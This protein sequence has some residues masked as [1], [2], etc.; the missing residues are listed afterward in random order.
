MVVTTDIKSSYAQDK[1]KL[2]YPRDDKSLKMTVGPENHALSVYVE[3]AVMTL[4]AKLL[5]QL[6]RDG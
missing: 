2:C 4:K 5:P 3:A 6:I 1:S